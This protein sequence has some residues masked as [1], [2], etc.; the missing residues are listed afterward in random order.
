MLFNLVVKGNLVAPR[1]VFSEVWFCI[2]G[3]AAP[4]L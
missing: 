4:L 2:T 1:F 3:S